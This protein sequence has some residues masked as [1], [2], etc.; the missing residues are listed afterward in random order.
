MEVCMFTPAVLVL[1]LF[2][3][4]PLLI[5]SAGVLVGRRG[6]PVSVQWNWRRGADTH[7]ALEE[8]V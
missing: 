6:A 4:A 1:L 2:C 3:I 8:D 5:F 7:P